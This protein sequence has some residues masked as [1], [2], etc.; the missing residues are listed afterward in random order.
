MGIVMNAPIVELELPYPNHTGNHSVRHT[1]SGGHYLT[2]EAEAY[3]LAVSLLVSPSRVAPKMLAGPLRLD[4]LI[5]P[6]DLRARDVDNLF[7][8]VCDALTRCGFW[9]DDSNKVITHG[10]WQ[11]TDPVPGGSIF[12]TASEA[13]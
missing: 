10:A 5:A 3:R 4:W 13:K 11:W 8:V 9:V 6:P 12:L 7:K 1:R 2:K